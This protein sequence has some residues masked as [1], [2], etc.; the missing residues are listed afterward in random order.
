MGGDG[1]IVGD[2][3]AEALAGKDNHES[4]DLDLWCGPHEQMVCEV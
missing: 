1:S 3:K 4:A 2:E